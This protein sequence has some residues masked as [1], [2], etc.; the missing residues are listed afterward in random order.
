MRGARARHL[1]PVPRAGPP[2]LRRGRAT[3][4][5]RYEA[6]PRPRLSPDLLAALTPPW[7]RLLLFLFGA[8]C[9]VVVVAGVRSV[10]DLLN[11][12]LMAGF[13]ALLLQPVLRALRGRL[14]AA[15][16][17]VVV[18]A[19]V[20]G[21]LALVGFVGVSLRQL[22]LEV[23][24]YQV[25]L[26]ALLDS[27]SGA[28]ADRG[29]DAAAYVESALT[30][31]AVA[32][33]V[34]NA[35]AAVASGF[36]NL[37]LTFFVFAFMIGGMWEMERRASRQAEDHSPTA[38]RFLA[39]SHTIRGYMAVRSVLGLAAAALNYV[40]L[41]VVGVDYA[42]LWAV[43]SFLLSFVP[44]VGFVLS[45]LP[46]MLLALL[47]QGWESALVVF[48]GYQVVNTLLDNVIGPRFVGR[49]M[50]ISP[51]LS[52]LSVIFWAWVLGATG[53]ILSV[54]LTVLIRDLAFG[55]ADP[56]DLGRPEP[57]T[58]SAVPAP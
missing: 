16:V 35:S 11:P 36:G 52:F 43:L 8:A 39:Y 25:Q 44:N 48:V 22:V 42:L 20:L 27:V 50:K 7:R 32:G 10:S 38:A 4:L 55:P 53:A 2:A 3:V 1:P 15:A 13:L 33:T 49:Q 5:R 26:R 21:G 45:M 58:P 37:V 12:V 34:L 56:P 23:P 31:P 51:L 30:G 28:L 41:L 18:L 24:R 9:A 57:V 29:I 19:V 17:A 46:P 54:P 14:G 40:L 47:G 6:A